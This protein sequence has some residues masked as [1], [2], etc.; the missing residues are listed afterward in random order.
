MSLLLD[1]TL[2]PSLVRDVNLFSEEPA[3]IRVL[4]K[5]AKTIIDAL[6]IRKTARHVKLVVCENVLWLECP[7][8]DHVM[9]EDQIGSKFI[10]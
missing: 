10:V 3:T 8:L 2:E 6:L 1:F 9:V 5:N 7:N 4:F